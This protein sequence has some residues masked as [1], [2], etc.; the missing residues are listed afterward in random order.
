MRASGIPTISAA[1]AASRATR[2]ALESARPTSSEAAITSRRPIK[3][4]S[5]P[6]SSIIPSQY[7]AASGSEPRMDLIKAEI[8]S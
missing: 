6:A 4:I 3:R 2:K 8:V 5:S 7:R 1:R